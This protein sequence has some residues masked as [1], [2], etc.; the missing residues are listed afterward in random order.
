MQMIDYLEA[1]HF[2][3]LGGSPVLVVDAGSWTR[4]A[5]PAQ[6]IIVGVDRK[7]DLPPANDLEFDVLLTTGRAAPRPWISIDPAQFDNTVQKLVESVN[8]SPVA[9]TIAAQ[10]LRLASA[11]SLPDAI[12]V[13]SF[14]YSALL[15][16]KEFQQ[17]LSTTDRGIE[18]AGAGE[19]VTVHREE[20]RI[21][22]TLN[23]PANRNAMSATMR[24]ALYEALANI[25]D[26]P[27]KPDVTLEAAGKCFSTGG[28]LPEFGTARD[29]AEAHV[30]RSLHSCATLLDALGERAT[31]KLH[32]ACVGS[33]I[34]IAAAAHHRIAGP[35]AWFQLPELSMGLI[36]G[37]GGTA[38]FTR[39]IGRHRTMWMLL[40]AKR[41][42]AAQAL[43]WGLVDAI[44]AQM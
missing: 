24:D 29:L 11:L 15:G 23:D 43:D 19:P 28:S 42:G 31:V 22:L 16:G 12:T 30:V 3:A 1:D 40:S 4:P 37:A 35:D 14:A 13:E 7:G 8:A 9:A 32:G 27:S 25:L 34:E 39:A 20:D 33:G 5:A 21:H 18:Q 38:T 36:P 44:R 26:D 6:A 17:W 2:S 41:I 10:V